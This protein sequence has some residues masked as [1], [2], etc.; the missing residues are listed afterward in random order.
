[1]ALCMT[2]FRRIQMSTHIRNGSRLRACV[3]AIYLPLGPRTIAL[4]QGDMETHTLPLRKP[5]AEWLR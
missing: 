1:M 3:R 2:C 4:A 5:A